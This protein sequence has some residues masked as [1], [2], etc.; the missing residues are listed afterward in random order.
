MINKDDYLNLKPTCL[1][2][3]NVNFLK[4][5]IGD[6][7]F[8]VIT[9]KELISRINNFYKS[10]RQWKYLSFTESTEKKKKKHLYMAG[11]LKLGTITK[12]SYWQYSVK[13]MV[14]I[15]SYLFRWGQTYPQALWKLKPSKI[16]PP[17][18]V[19][20]LA[21]PELGQR[22]RK[23]DWSVGRVSFSMHCRAQQDPNDDRET[24]CKCL[25]N[26]LMTRSQMSPGKGVW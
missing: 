9:I 12:G 23:S 14:S 21:K 24:K 17:M 25:A 16:F 11:D 13:L 6:N 1:L 22:G 4:S 2:K 15:V 5:T 10:R 18:G 20:L 8:I 26:P 19:H 7:I 3:D